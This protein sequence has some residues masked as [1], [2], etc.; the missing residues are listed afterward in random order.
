ML[1]TLSWNDEARPGIVLLL[2]TFLKVRFY[3]LK[4]TWGGA[5]GRLAESWFC[6]AVRTA[7]P[8]MVSKCH[9]SSLEIDNTL[10]NGE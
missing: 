6:L 1:L 5:V 4:A 8:M 7:V 3:V 10:L 2:I 9:F